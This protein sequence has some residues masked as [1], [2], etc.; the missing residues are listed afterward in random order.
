MTL[1]LRAS[2]C[3]LE[4]DIPPGSAITAAHQP[5]REPGLRQALPKAANDSR[6][7][8][9][10]PPATG[11]LVL[12]VDDDPEHCAYMAEVLARRGFR[13]GMALNG[14]DAIT[15]LEQEAFETVVTDIYMPDLDGIELVRAL[16]ERWPAL[17]VVAVTGGGLGYPS[18][19]PNLLK[20]LGVFSILNKPMTPGALVEAV[21]KINDRAAH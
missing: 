13:V 10:R 16:R 11:P 1:S 3:F 8:R 7:G 20:Y 9:L 14:R 18:G 6:P 4:F 17:K 5:G 21:D 12:V 15:C 19:V 2:E